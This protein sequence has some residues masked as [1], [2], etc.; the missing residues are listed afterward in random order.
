VTE[1]SPLPRFSRRALLAGAAA[2]PALGLAT[3]A[4]AQTATTSATMSA[5][6]TLSAA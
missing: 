2:T 5:S 4:G 1:T 3:P 6:A